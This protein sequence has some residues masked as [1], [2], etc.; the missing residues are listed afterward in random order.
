MNPGLPALSLQ[1]FKS[2]TVQVGGECVVV[3]AQD[4]SSPAINTDLFCDLLRQH[5]D[6]PC[7]S[8]NGECAMLL[9][10]WRGQ[11]DLTAPAGGRGVPNGG[12]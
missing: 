1:L 4:M 11:I 10:H 6:G 2:P 8:D 12:R 5:A 9:L 3:R 7:G